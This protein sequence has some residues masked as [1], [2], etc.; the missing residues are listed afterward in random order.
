MCRAPRVGRPIFEAHSEIER[1]ANNSRDRRLHG[2]RSA[3]SQAPSPARTARSPRRSCSPQAGRRQSAG[4]PC[5]IMKE[6]T[7]LL[8]TPTHINLE[9]DLRSHCWGRGMH[10]LKSRSS[11]DGKAHQLVCYKKFRYGLLLEVSAA[12][13]P[14]CCKPLTCAFLIKLF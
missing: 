5:H 13:A 8:D 12:E 14:L 6:S 1:D 3:G 9:C 4:K 2:R 10:P 7:M 11:S